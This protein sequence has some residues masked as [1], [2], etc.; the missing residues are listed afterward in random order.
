MNTEQKVWLVSFLF[1]VMTGGILIH[2]GDEYSVGLLEGMGV[3]I[4]AA[5]IVTIAQWLRAS[6]IWEIKKNVDGLPRAVSK[7]EE[8]SNNVK[9]LETGIDIIRS[10]QNRSKSFYYDCFERYT[11]IYII[12]IALTGLIADLKKSLQTEDGIF[13]TIR[14]KREFSLLALMMGPESEF[15]KHRSVEVNQERSI[16]NDIRRMKDE[17]DWCKKYV[18]ERSLWIPGRVEIS[19]AGKDFMMH[20]SVFVALD[21]N[22]RQG[23]LLLGFLSPNGL[24]LESPELRIGQNE[25]NFIEVNGWVRF[26]LDVMQRAERGKDVIWVWDERGSR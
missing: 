13:K 17:M 8:I 12:G 16:K 24:G 11:K 25:R 6:P 9:H 23:E 14:D 22:E 20:H 2:I 4:L 15:V 18:K 21:K 7:I 19:H 26:A 1:V 10:R 3:S 5:A